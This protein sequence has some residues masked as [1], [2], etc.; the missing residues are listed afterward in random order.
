MRSARWLSLLA[1]TV[2]FT[3]ADDAKSGSIVVWGFVDDIG[4]GPPGGTNYISIAGTGRAGF[5]LAADGSIT[6]WG[7]NVLG[8][9]SAPSGTG[10]TAVAASVGTGYALAA[11][12]SIR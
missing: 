11:D 9:V 10:Y 6:A 7:N 1:A 12:G 4:S 8:E 5:A 3:L 2:V